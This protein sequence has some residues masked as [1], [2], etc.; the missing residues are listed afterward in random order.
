MSK[1]IDEVF[2]AAGGREALRK[3]LGVSKQTL[4][5]WKRWGHVSA[6]QAVA[7]EKITSIPRQRLCPVFDWVNMR[8]FPKKA[9]RKTARA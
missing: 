6:T 8:P 9:T 4:S 5:D 2:A 7:V 3:A 1:V